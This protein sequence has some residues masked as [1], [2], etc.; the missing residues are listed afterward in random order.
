[1][2][3]VL[4]NFYQFF[5]FPSFREQRESLKQI[6]IDTQLKGTILLAPEGINATLAGPEEG[7]K[8]VLAYI[9]REITPQPLSPHLFW[10]DNVNLF[11]RIKVRL[12]R[13]IIQW[14]Q[15]LSTQAVD[16]HVDPQDWNALITQPDVLTIDTRNEYETDEGRFQG[17]LDPNIQYF[18]NFSSFA[19]DHLQQQKHKKIAIYC[20]G[21]IRCEK[22][23]EFLRQ[24]GFEHVYQLKGGIINYLKTI[25]ASESLWRGKCFVFDQRQSV[26][27]GDLE[28]Y[29]P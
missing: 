8:Q 4:A 6:C 15:A 28:V 24:E 10:T 18:S 3:H 5:S 22:V 19:R 2:R 12:K 20:T 25:P 7:I 1:M 21:G 17:A 14:G 13:E 16:T 27:Y 29:K 11:R 26:G 9:E 23:T